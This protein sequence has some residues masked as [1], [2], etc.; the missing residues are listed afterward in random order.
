[1][2]SLANYGIIA[3]TGNYALT[4][5]PVTLLWSG[6]VIQDIGEVTAGF[7]DNTVTTSFA[8]DIFTTA[9]KENSITVRFK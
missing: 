8:D 4:G 3:N 1:M 7:K 2:T 9:Y 6:D 5:Y